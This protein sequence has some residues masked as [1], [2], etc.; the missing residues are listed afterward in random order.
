MEINIHLYNKSHMARHSRNL[1]VTRKTFVKCILSTLVFSTCLN[2]ISFCS[3]NFYDEFI[4]GYSD[5]EALQ[6]YLKKNRLEVVSEIEKLNIVCVR[7][8]NLVHYSILSDSADLDPE[9]MF[10]EPNYPIMLEPFRNASINHVGTFMHD[11]ADSGYP[12]DPFWNTDGLTGL[13]QWNMRVIDADKAWELEPF[14]NEVIVSVIDTGIFYPH[15]D[16]SSSYMSGGYDWFNGDDDPIDDNGHGSWVSG[17]IAAERNNGYG[18]AGISSARVIAEK[19]LNE[20]GLG[21]ISN[22]IS[23]IIHSADLGADVI[24]ISLG[25]YQY[26]TPLELAVNYAYD[27]GCV[28]VASAGNDDTQRSR[29]P[30]S[31][32][33]VLSITATFGDPERLS[34]Y[35]NFGPWVD[36]SAPG[37]QDYGGDHLPD[38]GEY[39]I[40]SASDSIDGFMY[41]IGTSASTPHVSGVASL[42]KSANPFLTNSDII[43]ILK[44]SSDDLGE[45]GWDKYFGEGR[46]NAYTALKIGAPPPV[47]GDAKLINLAPRTDSTQ[48]SYCSQP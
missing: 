22:L 23:A 25:T 45:P 32:S 17:I 46:V 21:S 47:G 16:L 20:N 37:G 34:W 41:G 26:S 30:A 13:G 8:R 39:W 10:V 11:D 48:V 27:K 1:C 6:D 19:V 33:N 29:Y 24:S 35:S 40:L 28:I 18:V 42:L 5:T 14:E 12:D 7:S 44:E 3:G 9:I 2:Y 31:Y 4:I 36:L 43:D 15:P 38:E